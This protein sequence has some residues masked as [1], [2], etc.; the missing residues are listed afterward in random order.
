MAFFRY[1]P[2][3][4]VPANL[5]LSW[6]MAAIFRDSVAVA[7]VCAPTS[8]TASHGNHEKI[9]LWFSF[10]F[11]YTYGA[12]F[13]GPSGRRGSA[14]TTFTHNNFRHCRVRFFAFLRQ[15]FLKQLYEEYS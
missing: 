7:I 4:R 8:Y 11:L 5:A 2:R 9:N 14:Q 1:K 15:P 10:T 6:N 3:V 12:P 13:G